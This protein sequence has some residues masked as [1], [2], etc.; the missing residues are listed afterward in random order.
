MMSEGKEKED[1]KRLKVF[2]HIREGTRR[3]EQNS[4]SWLDQVSHKFQN[5]KV[6]AHPLKTYTTIACPP[7][8]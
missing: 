7:L 8:M 3:P 1:S 6:V 4:P 5:N 2:H